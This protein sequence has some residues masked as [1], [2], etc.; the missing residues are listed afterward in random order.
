MLA[1]MQADYTLPTVGT[2]SNC[3]H[4]TQLWAQ[5]PT[6]LGEAHVAVQVLVQHLVQH[7]DLLHAHKVIVLWEDKGGDH[8]D[9]AAHTQGHNVTGQHG[10]VLKSGVVGDLVV[11]DLHAVNASEP[12]MMYPS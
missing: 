7:L 9:D 8:A 11:L 1:A 12:G 5:P 10:V 3:W 6:D 2:N 4:K